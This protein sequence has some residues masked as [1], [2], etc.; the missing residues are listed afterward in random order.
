MI[1]TVDDDNEI[2]TIP[3]LR[4][5]SWVTESHFFT[6]VLKISWQPLIFIKYSLNPRNYTH[7]HT[8]TSIR[9]T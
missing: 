5:V 3:Q 2:S 9:N 1:D 8:H 4:I 6:S 7:T